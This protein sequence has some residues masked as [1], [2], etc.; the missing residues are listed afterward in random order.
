[1]RD[2]TQ[3]LVCCVRYIYLH[4][5]KV[6]LLCSTSFYEFQGFVSDK[7]ATLIIRTYSIKNTSSFVRGLPQGSVIGPKSLGQI[8]SFFIKLLAIKNRFL[9]KAAIIN[10]AGIHFLLCQLRH[11]SRWNR[12]QATGNKQQ[13][14]LSS[15]EGVVYNCFSSLINNILYPKL[16]PKYMLKV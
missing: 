15:T 7:W 8:S 10:S 12:F 13:L 2:C 9:V 14:L 16:Y 4:I 1:M 11:Y 3:I 6:S 5:Q